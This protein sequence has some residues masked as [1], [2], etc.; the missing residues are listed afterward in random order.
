MSNVFK[1][2][3]NKFNYGFNILNNYKLIYKII[4]VYLYFFQYR[5]WQ[6][7][8]TKKEK[9]G[10]KNFVISVYN[11]GKLITNKKWRNW[12]SRNDILIIYHN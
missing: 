2:L 6:L 1:I 11:I 7:K 5:N 12:V 9:M 8:N 3:F 10:I 4:I